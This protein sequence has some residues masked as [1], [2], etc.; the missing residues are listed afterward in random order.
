[1]S[2]AKKFNRLYII[3]IVPGKSKSYEDATFRLILETEKVGDNQLSAFSYKSAVMTYKDLYAYLWKH[4]DIGAN[5][6][7]GAAGKLKALQGDLSRYDI[8]KNK[9]VVILGE[10]RNIK[11][12]DE[13]LG[14]RVATADGKVTKKT[15][16]DTLAYCLRVSA[17]GGIPIANAKFIQ[18]DTKKLH[19]KSYL[20]SGFNVEYILINRENVHSKPAE[21]NKDAKDNIKKF[22]AAEKVGSVTDGKKKLSEIFTPAQIKELKDAKLAGVNLKYIANNKLSPEQMNVIWKCE[23]EKLPGR[24][25]ADP[26]YS[27]EL[28]D[29]YS[30]ELETGVD[31]R[32]MLNPAYTTEQLFELSLGYEQG[33]DISKYA[34][35]KNSV[36]VMRKKREDMANKIWTQYKV[37][38]GT[39]G[40]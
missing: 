26:E 12:R 27:I 34:N 28:M 6:D 5:I 40:K 8:S 23:A 39:L 22:E 21:V 4:T 10:I 15:V 9:V 2:I 13:L 7:A 32:I 16:S 19:L 38:E 18:S 36:E 33:V 29:F 35:P 11:N 1:M 37:L 30:A 31:I 24:L 3:G 25:F 17:E 20:S 14:Y